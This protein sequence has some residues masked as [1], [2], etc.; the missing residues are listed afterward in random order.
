M[1][2][3]RLQRAIYV[4]S[5]LLMTS[6]A[7]FLFNIIRFNDVI[8]PVQHYHSLASFLSIP[9]VWLGQALFPILMMGLYY[10]SGYYNVVF[11]RSRVDELTS[12]VSTAVIGT[13]IIY[14][15]AIVDDPIPDRASNYELLILL[16]VLLF[17]LVYLS[18]LI[19]TQITNN[20]IRHGRI[21]FN[22]LIIG[23]SYQAQKLKDKISHP[24]KGVIN[25]YNIVGYVRVPEADDADN[26]KFH[27][28]LP[29]YDIDN[30]SEIC[31]EL[32]IK[33]LII[34]PT[35]KGMQSVLEIVNRLFPLDLPILISPTLFQLITSKPK[36]G[37]IK[38][39]PLIDISHAN[40][41]ESTKNLKRLGDVVLSSI[42]LIMLYPLFLII[43]LLIKFDSKGPVFYLQERIGLRKKAFRIIKFRTMRTDAES[44]GP[45]LSSENDNRITRVGHYL[46]KYRLD[47][48][49]QFWNVIKGEMSVIGPRPERDYYIRQIVARAPYYTLVHQVRPGITSLGMVKH[50]YAKDVDE[51]VE[52]LQYDLIYI[53]NVSLTVDLKIMIYTVNT[54]ITGRGI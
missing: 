13:L 23:T 9:Q 24:K 15:L 37:N 8:E 31:R 54:V 53:E 22:T 1:V 40:M 42:A 18:R 51:M 47:E 29:V 45:A 25:F 28:D 19:I 21:A 2:S 50:G 4:V 26:H 3:V 43:S 14:F 7:W 52:R 30:I 11:F 17:T 10:L 12:T 35:K 33:Y 36:I 39:E 20:K 46:R 49:P 16:F 44:H 5:D 6:L 34:A 48:L 41:S 32:R 27:P 38:G